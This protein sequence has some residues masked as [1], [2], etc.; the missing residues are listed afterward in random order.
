MEAQ[1]VKDFYENEGWKFSESHSHDAHINENLTRVAAQ[2]V[3]NVRLRILENLGSG[4]NLLDIGCG[5]I[6]YPEYLLYSSNFELRVC[7]DL[8]AEALKLARVKLMEK[9]N[10]IVGDYLDLMNL[11]QAPFDGSTLI[12]VLYHIEK[13]NQEKF[14]R[15]IL[16]DL[17]PGARLVVVYSNPKT[18]SAVSTK[19]LV[20]LKK[21]FNRMSSRGQKISGV[22]PIYFYRHPLSFWQKFEDSSDVKLL[23]WRTFSP[24]LE[25]ILFRKNLLGNLLLKCL[26]QLEELKWWVKFAEYPMVILTKRE[27]V[28]SNL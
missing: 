8:S 25:Q 17:N 20:K 26:F 27:T 16:A 5:P 6:Q 23:A 14:V 28:E 4:K 11:P 15:K 24:Q 1:S 18:F 13:D 12:N 21:C 22:N 2:Y 10:Y 7:V 19:Y 3:T 9:G